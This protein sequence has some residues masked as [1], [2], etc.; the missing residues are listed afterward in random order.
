MGTTIAENFCFRANLSDKSVT[1][2]CILRPK[3]PFSFSVYPPPPS[4]QNLPIPL[5]S[6]ILKYIQ[7]AYLYKKFNRNIIQKFAV[8]VSFLKFIF[9]KVFFK[10]FNNKIPSLSAE[11][12][13]ISRTIYCRPPRR[14][15]CA[16]WRWGRWV[17]RRSGSWS[18]RCRCR[19]SPSPRDSPRI[20]GSRF[21]RGISQCPKTA[22]ARKSGPDPAAPKGPSLTL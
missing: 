5:A 18:G 4:F 9:Q 14:R 12:R 19:R 17:R 10:V 11:V 20:C 7:N 3:N 8:R 22:C 2:L 16:C 1:L 6:K 13:V 21:Q 15:T